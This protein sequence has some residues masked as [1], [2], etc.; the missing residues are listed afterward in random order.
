MEFDLRPLL[1]LVALGT[2][3]DL[4]PLVG[5]NR[6]L[7]RAGLERLNSTQRPGLS[8]LKSVARISGS[9]GV[10]EV[11]FQLA[12]R[13]NATGRLEHALQSLELLMAQDPTEAANLASSLD[14]QNR[15]R[16]KI[17]RGM[18]DQVIGAVRA[19]FNPATDYVIVEGQ[20]LWHLGVVGIVASRVV[21]EFYRPAIMIG[22][23][24]AEWRG[25]G[26]S[27]EGFDL[28]AAL[29]SCSDLLTRHGGHAMAAG[30][31]LP[32]EN[33]DLLRARLNEIARQTL[34]P[35]MLQPILPIDGE[36]ELKDLTFPCVSA[37]RRLEP[38]GQA[39]PPVRLVA[40]S[41]ALERPAQRVGKDQQHLKMRVTDGTA[42][43]EALWWNFDQTRLPT[44]RFDLAFCPEINCFH[45]QQFV[46]L[47]T[48]DW[49]PA[50]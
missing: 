39:N 44:G 17:E 22:G 3:A 15:E 26:R 27:I 25:S 18:A 1:D 47:R 36:T 5:E 28:A 13:L 38:L 24:G 23:D 21:R 31:S 30:L 32:A 49:R 48:L 4:V 42:T 8:A 37:F 34:P 35:E 19:R 16:Q 10:Y 9:I 12:P 20:M 29:R 2:I 41:L 33:L 14:T 45:D 46:Q 43:L 40:R 6:I 7:V 50:T 11:A